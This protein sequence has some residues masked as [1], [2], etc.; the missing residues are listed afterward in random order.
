[1]CS[2]TE[3]TEPCLNNS[4][5]RVTLWR[6]W[7]FPNPSVLSTPCASCC[8][9]PKGHQPPPEVF[10]CRCGLSAVLPLGPL[11]D[12]S[13]TWSNSMFHWQVETSLNKYRNIFKRDFYNSS[14]SSSTQTL[15]KCQL[16]E[17]GDLH[18]SS[19][20]SSNIN[21]HKAFFFFLVCTF[22]SHKVLYLLFQKSLDLGRKIYILS[23]SLCFVFLTTVFVSVATVLA[24][25][26]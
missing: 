18:I 11:G 25:S 13:S 10:Q 7:L 22:L 3:G 23:H 21:K 6:G 8:C 4:N 24:Q 14:P 19:W 5:P 12:T 15:P 2:C 20:K 26:V 16:I 17:W 9:Q 1:M